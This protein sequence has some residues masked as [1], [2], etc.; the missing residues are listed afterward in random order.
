MNDLT[1]RVRAT[2]AVCG[3]F[4]NREYKI[5]PSARVEL[6]IKSGHLIWLDCPEEE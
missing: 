3:M 4:A 2:T 5:Y 6:L 1:I